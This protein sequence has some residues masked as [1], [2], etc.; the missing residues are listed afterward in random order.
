MLLEAGWPHPSLNCTA[1]AAGRPCQGFATN[2]CSSIAVLGV[3]FWVWSSSPTPAAMAGGTANTAC[4]T[5][6]KTGIFYPEIPLLPGEAACLQ[7]RF[8]LIRHRSWCVTGQ[9]AV[10]CRAVWPGTLIFWGETSCERGA[11]KAQESCSGVGV[12]PGVLASQ[13]AALGENPPCGAVG[14]SDAGTQDLSVRSPFPPISK[15]GVAGCSCPRLPARRR[16]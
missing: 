15:P 11:A 8:Q 5:K 9:I 1:G 4:E 16:V 2:P 12:R 14:S 6:H 3:R 13:L 10:G 7:H